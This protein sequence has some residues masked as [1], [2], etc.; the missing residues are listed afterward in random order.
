M[1]TRPTKEVAIVAKRGRRPLPDSVMIARG[2]KQMYER[3]A[4]ARELAKK[5]QPEALEKA[6]PVPPGLKGNKEAAREWKRIAAL[7]VR[8]RVLAN[9][10][11]LCLERL[12]FMMAEWRYVVEQSNTARA[13][14]TFDIA[15]VGKVSRVIS[16]LADRIVRLE[17]ELGMT[18]ASAVDV[19]PKPERKPEAETASDRFFRENTLNLVKRA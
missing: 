6:P 17:R 4:K 8:R 3:K 7:L 15:E 13:S 11:L 1:E 14:G 10:D 16:N 12:C 2:S 9:T 18:P 5:D 19:Q